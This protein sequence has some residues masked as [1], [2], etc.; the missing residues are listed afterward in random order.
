MNRQSSGWSLNVKLKLESFQLTWKEPL[1]SERPMDI[2]K[3]MQEEVA[4]LCIIE[5]KSKLEGPLKFN[6][7]GR[8]KK[9]ETGR[10]VLLVL[11]EKLPEKVI[12]SELLLCQFR[13]DFFHFIVSFN[14]TSIIATSALGA[15]ITIHKAKCAFTASFC[16]NFGQISL[17][18]NYASSTTGDASSTTAR[19][20]N[21]CIVGDR[22]GC[23][24]DSDN[25]NKKFHF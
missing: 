13:K 24:N 22:S 18:S 15:V 16:L 4:V 23:S 7:I 2:G 19:T 20:T 21:F 25:G 12:Q 9:S 17:I 10:S 8:K 1:K 14:W 11:S 6:K 3:M 5:V